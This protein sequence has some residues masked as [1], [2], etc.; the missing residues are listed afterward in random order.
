[1][2][3][4]SL[5]TIGYGFARCGLFFLLNIFASFI[6]QTAVLGIVGTFIPKLQLYSR[7]ELLSFL[8]WLIPGITLFALF[9]D[10]AKRHTAYGR[11]N[12]PNVV[13]VVILTSV[14]YYAPIFL[15]DY[16]T[17]NNAVGMIHQ[18]YFTSEWLHVISYNVEIY[19]LI[20]TIVMAT[21]C[22]VSYALAR[23]YYLR[24]FESGEYE[25]EY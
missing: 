21:I 15:L 3:N 4:D 16:I 23:K 22:I 10:D 9:A 24:K 5:R 17:D 13:I 18:L 11:Y 8:S 7:P 2:E 6:G 25:Y 14:A 20:G 12:F 1:M 19:A